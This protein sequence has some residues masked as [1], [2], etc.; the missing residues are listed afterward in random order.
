MKG[1][2]RNRKGIGKL[3]GK[4]REKGNCR[5]KKT[6]F[7]EKGREQGSFWEKEGRWEERRYS[8]VTGK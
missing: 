8:E 4:G 3:L 2:C 1:S 7:Y 6:S 5:D